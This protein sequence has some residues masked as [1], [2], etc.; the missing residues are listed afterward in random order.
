MNLPFVFYI[1]SL[2]FSA[3][4]GIAASYV[5]LNSYEIVLFRCVF[6]FLLQGVLFLVLKKGK[7]TCIRMGVHNYGS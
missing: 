3:T 1:I 4:N 5:A 6:A 2:L 7:F